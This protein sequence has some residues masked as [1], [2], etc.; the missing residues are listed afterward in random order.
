M[1]EPPSFPETFKRGRAVK[2][3]Q[4]FQKTEL[5]V[6]ELKVRQGQS[7]VCVFV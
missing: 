7:T 3:K 1:S 4:S 5:N 2:D 6:M